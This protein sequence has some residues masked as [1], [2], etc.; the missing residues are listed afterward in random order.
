MRRLLAQGAALCAR[1]SRQQCEIAAAAALLHPAE[2]APPH[3][4]PQWRWRRS[5]A[6]SPA[7]FAAAAAAPPLRR[8]P[9]FSELTPADVDHFRSILG[10]RG[11]VTD[12]HALEP[13]NADWLGK[14]KGR[15]R[16]ALRPATTAQV[17]A[18]LKHC[19]ARR[20]AVVP[21]GGNTG[22]VGGGVPAFDEV[23][24]SLAAMDRV[25]SLDA[26]S[27][28]L[29][30]QA[31]CVLQ[32]LDE[33]AARDGLLVPLDLGAKGSCRIGG[34]VS[35]N[36]GG[37]RLVRYGSLHGSVLGVEAVLADGTVLDLLSTLRKDNTGYD[38][39]QLFIGS[40]GSLG[41]HFC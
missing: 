14:Y 13:Y 33:R 21:Q 6:T 36:A 12:E 26:A 16:L 8:D 25:L 18:V 20:L 24:L 38:L 28:A 39:K 31:G 11:V 34:N 30:A 27:G 15:A 32:A 10:D 1:R 29:V 23:V 17:A 41:E 35:T 7:P 3:S 22:L 9:R 19:S 2:L 5:V 37:L 40:E 4:P